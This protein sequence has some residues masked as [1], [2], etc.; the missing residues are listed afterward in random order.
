MTLKKLA[1]ATTALTMIAGAG[2]ADNNELFIDQPG[3][4]N[5]AL[6]DQGDGS[7]GAVGTDRQPITQRGDHNLIVIEQTGSGNSVGTDPIYGSGTNSRPRGD[8]VDQ[9]GNGGD[10]GILQL[11]GDQAVFE[12]QQ[13]GSSSGSETT[14]TVSIQQ[15][16]ADSAVGRINQVFRGNNGPNSVSVVQSGG[17]NR[18]GD[19][20]NRPSGQL[21][22]V[23]SGNEISISQSGNSGSSTAGTI[24]FVEQR[25]IGA[26]GTNRA[27]LNQSGT[28]SGNQVTDLLQVNDGGAENL[29]ETDQAG[30]N[31][32][33]SSVAQRGT[34]NTA[35][36]TQMGSDNTLTLLS[37]IGNFNNAT[38]Y[39]EGNGNEA[40]ISARGNFNLTEVTQLGTDG[41]A[42]IDIRF[43]NS[44]D[45]F[46][47][48]YGGVLGDSNEAAVDIRN[49]NNNLIEVS[50]D[51]SN[52]ADLAVIGGSRNALDVQQ[53][54]SNTVTVTITGNNNNNWPTSPGFSDAALTIRD[55]VR[56][57]NHAG[58]GLVG[59]ANFAQGDL[60][61]S[62]S[63]NLVDLNVSGNR[64]AFAT[65]QHGS[66][67]TIDGTISG[68]QNQA[69]IAQ[70]GSGAAT[71]FTQ[72]GNFNN[73]GV[74]Q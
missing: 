22:Q 62:G 68:N 64:N 41:T 24:M 50:Q 23:G 55:E 66:G 6:I 1:L 17:R 51:G 21:T 36:A 70:L 12:I 30:Q 60:F 56:G 63:G 42:S 28:G 13:R 7:N 73:L 43:G 38:T 11:G 4:M 49:G 71:T 37:Q 9:Y 25:N 32:R 18:L 19:Q 46:V 59:E 10:I 57:G 8:G 47:T 34:G 69:V 31:V 35:S 52:L 54:G 48:Q 58:N 65:Y 2:W 67:N 27:I 39:Q 40:S 20:Y 5:E 33:I 16:G 14:N 61:Q 45:V 3:N 15:F 53:V 72:A 26:A 74:T 29:V 44:N